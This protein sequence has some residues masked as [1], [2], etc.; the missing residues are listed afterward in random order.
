MDDQIIGIQLAFLTL[1]QEK[2][3]PLI[4]LLTLNSVLNDVT[5]FATTATLD[6]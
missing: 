5:D 3:C 4:F 6:I 2:K 1:Y